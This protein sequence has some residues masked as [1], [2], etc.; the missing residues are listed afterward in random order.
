MLMSLLCAGSLAYGGARLRSGAR[1]VYGRV[2]QHSPPRWRNS[3]AGTIRIYEDSPLGS[4]LYNGQP[5]RT[6]RI[7]GGGLPPQQTGS[8]QHLKVSVLVN[9]LLC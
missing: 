6:S 4:R 1:P 2:V 8:F 3:P 9:M 7:S 5:S